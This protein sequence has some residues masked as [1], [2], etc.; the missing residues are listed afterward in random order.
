LGYSE[1][2]EATGG[3]VTRIGSTGYDTPEFDRGIVDR[4]SSATDNREIAF[5]KA[6]DVL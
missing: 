1:L 4:S 5:V 6:K 3:G 2:I